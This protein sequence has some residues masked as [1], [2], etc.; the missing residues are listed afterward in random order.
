M[1][2][3]LDAWETTHR[4]LW[5]FCHFTRDE[6][7][8]AFRQFRRASELDSSFALP[9]GLLGAGLYLAVAIGWEE[10]KSL[11]E[12]GAAAKS[13]LACDDM[14]P[15][16]NTTAGLVSIGAREYDA[17]FRLCRRAVELN[18]SFAFGHYVLGFAHIMMA[19]HAT[20]SRQSIPPSNLVLRTR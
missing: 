3:N 14:E 9:R 13:A 7:T 19:H 12:A 11:V 5:H 1:S 16:A 18:P 2:R 15:L 8:D 4:G 20:A 10:P 6:V 17:G